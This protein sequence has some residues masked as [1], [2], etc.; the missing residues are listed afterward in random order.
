M[1]LFL[2]IAFSL[3]I[4]LGLQ[5]CNRP[6]GER[7]A[8]PVNTEDSVPVTQIPIPFDDSNRVTRVEII[9]DTIRETIVQLVPAPCTEELNQ[10]DTLKAQVFKLRYDIEKI[11]FY[12]RLCVRN[13]SQKQF[14]LGWV[15]R[16]VE[17]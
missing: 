3:L 2:L 15:R 9:R 11:K 13:P 7:V 6:Q 10:I 12:V 14:L 16:V 1:R 8:G 4:G 5:K 17:Q